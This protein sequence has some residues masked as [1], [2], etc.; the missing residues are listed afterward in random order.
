MIAGMDCWVP[1]RS[2]SC[3]RSAGAATSAMEER[4]TTRSTEIANR[5]GQLEEN[6]VS[7]RAAR[8]D[9]ELGLICFI[10]VHILILNRGTTL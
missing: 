4:A 6:C 2:S 9:A 5:V 7:E 1:L 8:W 3:S 10:V